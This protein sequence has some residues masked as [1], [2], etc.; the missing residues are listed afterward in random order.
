M[1]LFRLL[2]L[3]EL[4]EE[5]RAS[6]VDVGELEEHLPDV[7][8]WDTHAKVKDRIDQF[9]QVEPPTRSRD[10]TCKHVVDLV[11]NVL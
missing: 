10:M 9:S 4:V 1:F 3:F 8:R 11:G 7:R 6:R 5:H 2:V